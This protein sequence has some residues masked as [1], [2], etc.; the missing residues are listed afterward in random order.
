MTQYDLLLRNG[1]IVDGSGAPAYAGSV[2]VKDGKVAAIGDLDDV[3]ADRVIDVDGCVIAPGFIDIHSHCD[4][5]L[6]LPDQ[7]EFLEP[8]VRQGITTLVIGNCGY[9]PA[10]IN[11]A[12]APLMQAYT[13]FI[14]PRDL[15]WNWRTFGEYLDYLERAR[16]LHEHGP[17]RRARR[18]PH[19]RHGLRGAGAERRGAGADETPSPGVHGERGLR[20]V[21]RAHLRAWH[22]RL[23]RRARCAR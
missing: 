11:P 8:F 18:T 16:R 7:G 5:I 14:K 20:R 19:R 17:A 3:Q 4:F 21:V 13:A 12:T 9:A 1:R 10:P 22:V 2:A 23:D 6:P 15:E